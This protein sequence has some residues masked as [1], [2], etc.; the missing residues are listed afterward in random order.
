MPDRPAGALGPG[1]VAPGGRGRGAGGDVRGGGRLRLRLLCAQ[2]L[3]G[4]PWDVPLRTHEAGRAGGDG[5]GPVH[6]HLLRHAAV[7]EPGQRA[8]HTAAGGARRRGPGAGGRGGGLLAAAALLQ[9]P[10]PQT[11]APPPL[12][13]GPGA[14]VLG[15][16]AVPRPVPL[17]GP[18]R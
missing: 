13:W 8:A 1:G 6:L 5:R 9:L 12:L 11:P 16:V 15:L 3:A 2:A 7:R 17:R 18:Q 14:G 4:R 10:G